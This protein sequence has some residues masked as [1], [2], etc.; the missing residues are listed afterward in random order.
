M[1][2]LHL[3]CIP[4]ILTITS[5]GSSK[6]SYTQEIEAAQNELNEFYLNPKTSPLKTEELIAFKKQGGHAFYRIDSAFKVKAKLIKHVNPDTVYM[7]TSSEKI[8]SFLKSYSAQFK[9]NSKSYTLSLYQNIKLMND[10]DH[11]DYLFLPF[12]DMT[13]G[14]ET[15]G[16]GRY[17]DLEMPTSN[18]ISID[19]N[20]AY[21]PYCAY[22]KG[23]SCPVPPAENYVELPLEAGIKL[24]KE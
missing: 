7:P 17:I 19:F 1:K 14:K 12:K 10:P 15:Y 5:C 6:D 16:G 23:Y 4:I 21:H 18:E 8:K 24:R 20:K 13:T 9:L 3:F 22:T 2:V 11:Q